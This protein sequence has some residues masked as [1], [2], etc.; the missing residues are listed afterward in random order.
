MF[1]FLRFPKRRKGMLNG[2]SPNVSVPTPSGCDLPTRIGWFRVTFNHSDDFKIHEVRLPGDI[3]CAFLYIENMIDQK[4]LQ[5]QVIAPL[6][7][8]ESFDSADSLIRHIAERGQIPVA[9]MTAVTEI[10]KAADAL[11]EGTIVML[12]HDEAQM[13]LFPMRSVEK[14]QIASAENENVIR[15]PRA[16]FVEDLATNVT[17]VRRIIKHP[18]LKMEH[19][20]FGTY[21]NTNVTLCYIEGLCEKKLVDEVKERMSR[22]DIDNVLGS[23]YIEDFIEDNPFSPFPQVQYTERPDT[24][25]AALLEGRVGIMVDGTPVPMLVPVTLYMLLQSAEDYYQRFVAA[26]WIRWIRYLF[27]LISFLLPSVYIAVTTFHPEMLP[28]NLLIT[29]AAARE[30]VPFPAI[31][32]ALIMEITFEALREAGIRIPKPIGQTVSIIGALVIGQSA[33]Q[34]GIV[35]APMVI[36]VSITGIASFIIP[37]FDLGLTFRLLRFPVMFLATSFGLYGIIIAIILIYI[38]LVSLRSFG[39]P[40]LSPT[41]PLV[42]SDLKDVLVRAPHWL[43]KNRPMLYGTANRKRLGSRSRLP[44]RQD[45][46]D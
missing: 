11:F 42:T 8:E 1:S 27:L 17:M 2:S 41:A 45:D 16:A 19:H 4:M 36:V 30:N 14:R 3:A 38:H 26:T 15:G 35:S 25:S 6:L 18:D 9:G 23:S 37:H 29:V 21:T 13:L 5:Q 31:V 22:I 32:E 40:Y 44:I 24:F 43:M 33:V 7:L 12:V 34:A 46:G 10:R 20:Q 28:P 39:T